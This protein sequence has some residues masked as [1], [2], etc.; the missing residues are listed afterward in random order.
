M[1]WTGNYAFDWCT[2]GLKVVY[3]Y[4]Y[5]AG[6]KSGTPIKLKI[7]KLDVSV[8]PFYIVDSWE[9]VASYTEAYYVSCEFGQGA[10]SSTLMVYGHIK[11]AGFSQGIISFFDSCVY[12]LNIFL[13]CFRFEFY[14][15]LNLKT[16]LVIL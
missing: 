10:L 9:S 11:S 3:P 1:G 8:Y 4:A 14:D 16:P 13:K 2:Y 5:V 7:A 6:F 15:L 12:S